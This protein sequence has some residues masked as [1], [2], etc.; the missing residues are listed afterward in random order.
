MNIRQAQA[1]A[2]KSINARD[3][4]MLLMHVL[5]RGRA[6]LLAHPEYEVYDD[7]LHQLRGLVRRRAAHEPVQYITGVQEFYTLPIRVT[8]AVLIP[9]PETELLV[10]AV[11][12]WIT[13]RDTVKTLAL[14]D[15]GTGSGAIA[16][17]LATHVAA[18]HITA[19]DISTDALAVALD[20]VRAHNCGDRITLIAGDLLSGAGDGSFDAVISNPPYVPEADIL[21]AEVAG[22]EPHTALF[23]GPDGLDIYRRLIPEAARVLVPGGLLALEFGFGQRDALSALLAEGWNEIR[24]IHDYAGIP[25]IVLAERA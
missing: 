5:G 22:F 12:L 21:Q 10:E 20:N 15:V 11:E 16:V 14:A 4:Q 8:P 18:V 9:R 6:W 24:F 25:R 2:A 19:I 3:A 17:A 23:A 7:T 13:A 1:E